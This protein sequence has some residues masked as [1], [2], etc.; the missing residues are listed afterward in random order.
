MRKVL[1][2]KSCL[3]APMNLWALVIML[4]FVA[5]FSWAQTYNSPNNGPYRTV[6]DGSNQRLMLDGYDPVA[7]FTQN[8]AVLGD[9]AISLDH[10]GGTFRFASTASR[11]LF[12]KTPEQYKPQFGGFCSN[13]I[14]Y[15]I[16]A[17]GGP[18]TWRIYRGKLY[19][20]GGRGARDLFELDTERN[21]ELAH[22]YW[23]DEIA[24]VDPAETRKRRMNDRVP[25]Y[26]SDR[27]LKDEWEAKLA[28]KTLPVMPGGPQVVP[29]R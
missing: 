9:P 15:A 12:M 2:L 14:P 1:S 18:D 25:N 7:Y 17:G 5:D 26:R 20:F 4:F 11:E 29:A 27:S 19:V 13:G 23:N 6:S 10:S 8:A 28:A 21:L 22:K 16:P 24:G 3:R